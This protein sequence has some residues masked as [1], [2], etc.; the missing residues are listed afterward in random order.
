MPFNSR[1]VLP[2][3]NCTTR[4]APSTGGAGC[5]GKSFDFSWADFSWEDFSA[6]YTSELEKLVT[7]IALKTREIRAAEGRK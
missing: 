7:A 5:F 4:F 3:H 6:R 2:S 1:K